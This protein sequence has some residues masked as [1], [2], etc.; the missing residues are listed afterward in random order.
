MR[1]ISLPPSEEWWFK[2]KCGH[3]NEVHEAKIYFNLVEKKEMPGSRGDASYIAKCKLCERVSS[4]EYCDNSH[5]AYS[6][7]NQQF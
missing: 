4:V 6:N 3:C 1:E 5:R 7:Q 2:T